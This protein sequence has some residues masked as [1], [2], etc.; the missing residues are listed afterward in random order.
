M[1]RD[2][3]V[4][5]GMRTPWGAAQHVE[6]F[7]PGIGQ[8]GTASHGGIKLS[9]ELNAAVPAY[10]RNE[11]G[12][13]EEDCD[14]AIPLTVFEKYLRLHGSPCLVE[15]LDKYPPTKTLAEWRP[16][17]Y[18]RYFGRKLAPEESHVLR[19]RAFKAAHANDYVVIAA[20]G[21][22]QGGVPNGWVGV[23]ATLG[24]S[25]REPAYSQGKYFLVPATE[26]QARAGSFVIDPARHIEVD[27]FTKLGHKTKRVA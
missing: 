24:E 8:V 21:D 18:E 13:Y 2:E 17:A 15:S 9:D 5:E 3:L 22:W 27:D 12:W 10:M 23:F 20:W 1:P 25:R 6:I 14:C 19:D 4:Y 26:Y 11:S 7:A 16:D